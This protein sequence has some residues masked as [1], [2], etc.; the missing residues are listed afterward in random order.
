MQG[1][2]SHSPSR[3][4]CVVGMQS[5]RQHTIH[6]SL[7]TKDTLSGRV[8]AMQASFRLRLTGAAQL[9]SAYKPNADGHSSAFVQRARRIGCI[10]NTC[11]LHKLRGISGLAAL[12]TTIKLQPS[13]I[14]GLPCSPQPCLSAALPSLHASVPPAQDLKA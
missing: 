9:A 8:A 1:F 10:Y 6:A 4:P 14:N 3:D 12:H 13:A 7:A 5:C 2:Q 11:L